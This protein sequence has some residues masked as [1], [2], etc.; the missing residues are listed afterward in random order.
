LL[1][2]PCLKPETAYSMLGLPEQ[3]V[4]PGFVNRS[5]A[6]APG[7][8]ARA[9]SGLRGLARLKPIPAR[10]QMAQ[11]FSGRLAR[12]RRPSLLGETLRSK[13]AVSHER[14]VCLFFFEQE[15]TVCVFAR[16][17]GAAT[18][19]ESTRSCSDAKSEAQRP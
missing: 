10:D 12:V 7:G 2:F 15:R 9:P 1:R 13:V 4:R 6:P 8:S 3:L 17:D 18:I 11:R 5:P 19:L 14:A 16:D